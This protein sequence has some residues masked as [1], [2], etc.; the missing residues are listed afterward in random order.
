MS[1]FVRCPGLEASTSVYPETHKCPVCKVDVEIWSDERKGRCPACNKLIDKDALKLQSGHTDGMYHVEVKE[2]GD[3]AG[4]AFYFEQYETIV[5]VSVFEYSSKYKT[6]CKACEKFGKNF[7][8]PPFSPDFQDY[9]TGLKNAKVLAIRMPQEY[10]NQ[11]IQENI[12]AEC[13]EKA[14]QIL[15][16]ELRRYRGKN[17]L[18]AGAGYCTFCETCAAEEGYKNCISPENRVYSLESL[19]VNIAALTKRCFGFDLSWNAQEQV[20]NFVCSVGAVFCNKKKIC[21]N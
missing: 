16:E 18:I 17:S 3:D 11:V 4:R 13:F 6:A 14:R 9:V 7:A 5:P 1:D 15:M 20:N 8:C 12:Y 10:F 21:V 2:Y 19:G